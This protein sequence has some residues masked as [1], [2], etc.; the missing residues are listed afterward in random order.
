MRR[1]RI[2]ERASPRSAGS[3]S[4]ARSREIIITE[5]GVASSSAKRMSRLVTMPTT[6]PP[7][8][9]TGKPVTR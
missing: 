1:A 2:R 4:T 6:R 3:R 8:S 9:T 5:T 7:A